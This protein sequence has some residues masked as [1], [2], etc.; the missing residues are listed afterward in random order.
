MKKKMR[1]CALILAAMLLAGCSGTPDSGTSLNGTAAVGDVQLDA[2]AADAAFDRGSA[3]SIRFTDSGAEIGGAGATADGRA[4]TITEAGTY[5][6]EGSCADG[7]VTV[8]AAKSDKI[9]LVLDGLSLACADGA[10]LKIAEAEKVTLTLADGTENHL[11]DGA[12]YSQTLD[13]SSVDGAIFSKADLTVNGG[14]SLTVT[15]NYK[16]G[17]VSKDD[18]IIAGGTLTVTAES[19]ALDGKDCV[20]I[21]GGVLDITAGSNGI[22]S[23]NAEDAERGYVYIGGGTLKIDAGTDGIEAVTLLQIDGGTLD[24]R[25]GGGSANASTK[26]DSG[27][28]G[29]GKW[30][31]TSASASDSVSAKALKCDGDIRIG[32]GTFTIDSS[33]DAL[34]ANGSITVTDGTF[35]ISS[36]DD[37][38]H[39]DATLDIRGG[40]W[41]ITKS[42]EGLEAAVVLVSGGSI[43]LTASD[44]GLNAA[45]GSDGSA[46]GTR[47]GRNHFAADPN[48][49]IEISGGMLVI[50]AAGDGVDSN[51]ALNVSGGVTLI[52]GP[53][54]SGNGALDYGGKAT[55]TGGTFIACGASG[56]AMNFTD[57]TQC[58]VLANVSGAAGETVAVC[59]GDGRVIVSFTPKKN[60]S[61]ILV[62]APAMQLGTAYTV[63]SGTVAGADENGYAA[64]A[65]ISNAKTLTSFTPETL[66][67]GSAGGGFGG[68]NRDG[69]FGDGGRGNRGEM[70]GMPEGG[71]GGGTPP[72]MP[73]DGFGGGTPPEMPGGMPTGGRGN[74]GGK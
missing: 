19:T 35:A 9:Q 7:S 60:Y 57:G 32:G 46:L 16:H 33:D 68:G 26:S 42:Y 73:E 25:T 29:W 74:R 18:L 36:G 47:P 4:V 37:G 53:Q 31:G 6:L 70:P 51:G 10:P 63:A 17:I 2:G 12:A 40:T 3:V 44:D 43:R 52:S 14:G 55:I 71:F 59:G 50:D 64:D 61:S 21:G 38:V 30:G 39:A 8:S 69:G 45:G 28:G 27:R 56:M 23:D 41:E 67:S 48:A 58:A 24:I 54:N 11:A 72:G 20:K 66:I 49:R 34:H 65:E 5:L 22:R 13:D 62:S 15:G 1:P